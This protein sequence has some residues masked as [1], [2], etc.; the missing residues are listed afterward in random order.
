MPGLANRNLSPLG[1][2]KCVRLGRITPSLAES[3]S[4][5]SRSAGAHV[6]V[7]GRR[8]SIGT[9]GAVGAA[10]PEEVV[11]DREAVAAKLRDASGS[12]RAGPRFKVARER[13]RIR[14]GELLHGHD[15]GGRLN[16]ALGTLTRLDALR[17][18][19]IFAREA[20]ADEHT[21]EER[22]NQRLA[23]QRHLP[24]GDLEIL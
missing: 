2:A 8:G 9:V 10:A 4:I 18:R 19:W 5:S 3:H 15:R 24:F 20:L 14:P 21:R 13:P 12:D 6:A 1:L 23:F 22:T 7:P 17:V 11:D 16:R